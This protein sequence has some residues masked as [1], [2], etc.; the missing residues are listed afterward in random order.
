MWEILHGKRVYQDKEYDRELQEQ[1]VVNDKRPEVVENV[2]ECYLSLMKKCWVR[3]QN[4]RPTAEEIEEI[5]IKWQ[6]DEKVLLEF[7][8]SEKTLKN[9]NEQTYFEAPSESSYVSMMLNLPN[10]V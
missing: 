10:N 5:L 3:E 9:V 1:I 7:S 4:K 2:P 8:V 6:N